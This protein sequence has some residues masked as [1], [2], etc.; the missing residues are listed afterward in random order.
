[1]EAKFTNF[2]MELSLKRWKAIFVKLMIISEG[3]IFFKQ[4]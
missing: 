1:M 4:R 3:S 2:K